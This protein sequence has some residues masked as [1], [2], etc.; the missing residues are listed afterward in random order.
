MT[1]Q[2]DLQDRIRD[3]LR[4]LSR[5]ELMSLAHQTAILESRLDISG[6][7]TDDE[8]HAWVFET[9]GLD[10]PRVSVCDGHDAPFKFFSDLYFNRVN[11]ALAMA[12]RGG[13][14]T[15]LVALL[16]LTNSKFKPRI[17]SATVG[18]IEAQALRCYAH[19][20][21]L[22]DK[23]PDLKAD[24]A[25]S[26]MRETRWKNGA[27]VEV[28]PGTKAAVNGPHPNIVHADEVELMDPEVFDE[29]RNMSVSSNGHI[30]QDILTSTRKGAVGP[31]QTLI[32]EINEATQAGRLAPYSFYQWC[33]F[34]TAAKVPNCQRAHPDHPR[35]CNCQ[36]VVKGRW[37]S[38]DLRTFD[39]VCGGRLARSGGWMPLHDLHKTFMADS[40]EIWEAQQ[41]CI[42]PSTEGMVLPR[43]HLHRYGLKGYMPEPRNGPIF[44]GID[45]GGTN[46]HAAVYMQLLRYEIEAT[47]I[48]G[49]KIR[50]PEGSLVAFDEIYQAEIG[51]QRF[52]DLIIQ[53]EEHWR[54][55]FKAFEPLRRF[56]DPQGKAARLDFHAH[57][58]PVKTQFYCSRDVKE[59]IKDWRN[60]IDDEKFFVDT[61]RC[62][63]FCE[64]VIAWHY[65][66]K[67]PEMTDDPEIP[68]NDFDHTMA[69]SRYCIAN[70]LWMERRRRI[71]RTAGMPTAKGKAQR[72]KT[73][74]ATSGARY[75]APVRSR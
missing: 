43:F 48:D 33:V 66:K 74:F 24:V 23:V 73:I 30:A 45:F 63:M 49:V 26:I 52:A 57:K 19:L 39:Q 5:D 46:P 36:K 51:N 14:K 10:I 18:A 69:A 3:N 54:H 20:Q 72:K 60:M 7:A 40:R 21:S 47:R 13:S 58:P 44:V 71:S 68:V 75:V 16:H 6:P 8:L 15:F 64:E 1:T 31:M 32:N 38:G 59:H 27:R 35:P 56:P 22:M 25:H 4:S 29:S 9:F 37:D 70:V 61:Q 11:S 50:L 41:E 12:N 17:E 34:E 67:K 2:P 55:R 65:P 42:R 28:L 53:K 62:K